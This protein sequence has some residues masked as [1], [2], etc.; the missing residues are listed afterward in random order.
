MNIDSIVAKIKKQYGDDAARTLNEPPKRIPVYS[1][2]VLYVDWALGVGGLPRGKMVEFFGP[3]SSGKT[4]LALRVLAKAQKEKKAAG[5]MGDAE[6]ALDVSYAKTLG[7]DMDRL[8]VAQPD[9]GETYFDVLGSFLDEADGPAIE[10]LDSIASLVP[11]AE[12][13]AEMEKQ[14]IGLQA[15]MVTKGLRKVRSRV[16]KTDS[17]AIF[18]NQLREK[19]GVMYGNP[20]TTPGGR[21]LKHFCDIRIEIKPKAKIK[22]KDGTIIGQIIQLTVVKNKVAVPFRKAFYDFIYGVGIDYKKAFCDCLAEN[23]IMNKKGGSYTYKDLDR[24]D[25][26]DMYDSLGPKRRKILRKRLFNL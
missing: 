14:S 7:V 10:I 25:P 9:F 4:T 3:E 21:A 1:T 12:F 8:I 6:H 16:R 11:K 20:E 13:E 24:L 15:R 19:P 26:H 18:T 22:D 17:L 5:L 23:G 2:G